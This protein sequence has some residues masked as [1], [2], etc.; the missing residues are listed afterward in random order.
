MANQYSAEEQDGFMRGFHGIPDDGQLRVMSYIEL[1]EVFH[2]CEKDS[3]KFHVVERE[4]KRRLAKDQA[5]VNRSNILFGT[6]VG[7]I[8]NLAGVVLGY[9]L[10]LDPMNQQ[11]APVNALQQIGN[12]NL[13]LKNPLGNVTVGTSPVSQPVANPASA[14]KNASLGSTPP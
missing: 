14:A 7:G 9:C 8:F 4:V 2:S 10:R 13:T 1:S 6:V 5:E 12:S 11:V 3:T